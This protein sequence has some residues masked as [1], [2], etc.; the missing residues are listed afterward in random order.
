MFFYELH[1]GDDEVYSDVLVV[2]ESEWEPEEFFELVQP[3]RR[4]SRTPTPRYPQSRPSPIELERDHGFIFVSDDR[5]PPRSTS[6]PWRRTT[7]SR[8]RGRPRRRARTTMTTRRGRPTRRFRSILVD[9][10]PG[11]AAEL[12]AV[13]G[14]RAAR[15]AQPGRCSRRSLA[16]QDLHDVAVAHPVG[17]ALRAQPAGLARL[18]H[19][20][21]RDA[22]P[23]RRRSRPG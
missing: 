4:R 16:E 7:S 15:P 5:W 20:A 2:S 23:R 22:G 17:L 18:G 14:R 21:E 3:I 1:E 19:R 8:P 13:V 9:L 12:G 6:R 11:G 10:D